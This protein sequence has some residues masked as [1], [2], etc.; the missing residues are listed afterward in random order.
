[1]R[2]IGPRR[3]R[4]VTSAFAFA[5][6]LLAGCTAAGPSASPHA[7]SPLPVTPAPSATAAPTATPAPFPATVTDDEGNAVTLAA[8]PQKIVSL[9]P[10][11]TE[12]LY[13]VGAGPRVVAKVEDIASYPPEASAVPVVATYKGVDVEKIVSLGADLV[14][15]GGADFG[16]GDAVDQLRKAKIPVLVVKPTTTAGVVSDIRFIGQAAG[17][18]P[19]ATQLADTMAAGFDAIR[20]ATAGV[21]HPTVFYET[22]NAPAIYGIADGSVYAEL[23]TLAGGTP[24][25]TGSTTNYE[26]STEKL[27][28]ADPALILLGDAAY[29]VTADEVKARPGWSGLSAVKSGSIVPVDDLVIT[30]PGPRMLLGLVELVHA[31]HPELTLPAGLPTPLPSLGTSPSP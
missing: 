11:A 26:M 18:G 16:Q 6:M 28:A 5:F 2:P 24:V 29:G 23:I 4:A 20:T 3:Q 7:T 14:I 9:T 31:I 30:R 17:D 25:T 1:M 22:G 12:I 21:A 15:S 8:E 27:V 19:A 13:A 10:A